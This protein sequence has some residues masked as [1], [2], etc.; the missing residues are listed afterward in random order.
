MLARTAEH[1]TAVEARPENIRKA[2]FV[3]ELAGVDNVTFV[4]QDLETFDVRELGTFDAV[5]CSG[6]L[7]HLRHPWRLLEQIAAVA[8]HAL[9]WTHY[10]AQSDD[11]VEENG[12][13]IKR[14]PEEFPE[15]LLRGTAAFAS[16]FTREGLLE[17]LRR[18]GFDGVEALA[19]DVDGEAPWITLAAHQTHQTG[20]RRP[21]R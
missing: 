5:Y 6:I 8:P 18:V 16:W 20:A 11:L 9:V 21:E 3:C 4:E 17:E 14:V 10:W 19:E 12:R 2:E 1:V 15:P 7:Y 13:R